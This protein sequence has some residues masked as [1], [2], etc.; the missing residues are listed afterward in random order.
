MPNPTCAGMNDGPQWPASE[1]QIAYVVGLQKERALPDGYTS[2]GPDELRAMERDEVSAKIAFLNTLPRKPG[3]E[4]TGGQ[5][6]YDMPEARYALKGEDGVWRFYQVDK[7]DKGRWA[8]YVF[9]KQLIGAPGQYRKE[10][11]PA[12]R[13]HA[14]LRD[15]E[16][17]YK[18]AM[19]DYGLQSN[20]CGK[21]HSPLTNTESRARGIGP[22]CAGKMG[23]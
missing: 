1:K 23:W 8:G 22:K 9:I 5:T 11:P 17:D 2:S 18:Q 21:C 20:E 6:K 3:A 16:K 19:I 7:P 14:L 13:R 10:V 4:T 12:H 15:I